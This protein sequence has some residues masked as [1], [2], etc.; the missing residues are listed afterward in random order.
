[1]T[2]ASRSRLFDCFGRKAVAP[3]ARLCAASV[4]E[5]PA[6]TA[7][8]VPVCMSLRGFRLLATISQS[9]FYHWERPRF[10][11]AANCVSTA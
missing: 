6:E 8:S 1:V 11:S 7:T 9:L 5:A 3:A 4:S 10:G 2:A